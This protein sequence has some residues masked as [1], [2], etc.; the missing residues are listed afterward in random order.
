MTENTL[1]KYLIQIFVIKYLQA[2]ISN[3]P[4]IY[5]STNM[6]NNI[7]FIPSS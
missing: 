7:Y 3:E 6:K 1:N 5:I 4:G 2:T